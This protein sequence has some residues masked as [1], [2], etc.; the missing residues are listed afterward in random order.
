[1]WI[2]ALIAGAGGQIVEN[3]GATA[4][5]LKLGLETPAGKEAASVIQQVASTGVGGPALS[6][7]TETEAPAT[8]SRRDTSG[9]MVNWPYVWAALPTNGP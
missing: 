3:P 9:F 7:T 6:S 1:M 2:N 8:S 4:D 5:Q